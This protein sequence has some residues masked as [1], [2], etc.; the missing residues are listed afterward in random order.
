MN[1]NLLFNL[2]GT[3]GAFTRTPESS[4]LIP[5]TLLRLN[6]G[7]NLPPVLWTFT[8]EG[9]T[10]PTAMTSLGGLLPSFT[11]Y[12]YI[13]SSS[14]YDLVAKTSNANVERISV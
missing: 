5:G 14:Q 11:P 4:T 13:D 2:S 10:S 1:L 3:D 8:A 7:T 6:C 9:S 12:F